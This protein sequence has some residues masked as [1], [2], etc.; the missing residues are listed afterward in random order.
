MGQ[1]GREQRRDVEPGPLAQDRG[2]LNDVVFI[3]IQEPALH[4]QEVQHFVELV[5][6]QFGKRVFCVVKLGLNFGQI[7]P[8]QAGGFQMTQNVEE[9]PGVDLF[10]QIKRLLVPV[11]QD[12]LEV[13]VRD[14]TVQRFLIV[15]DQM[16]GLACGFFAVGDCVGKRHADVLKHLQKI[17]GGDNPECGPVVLR[18]A[19]VVGEHAVVDHPF[20]LAEAREVV[21]ERAGGVVGALQNV[22]V[23]EIF[24]H[25]AHER[26]IEHVAVVGV[27]QVVDD[28]VDGDGAVSD[29]VVEVVWVF[30]GGRRDHG[31]LSHMLRVVKRIEVCVADVGQHSLETDVRLFVEPRLE[32]VTWH[33]VCDQRLQLD[34]LPVVRVVGSGGGRGA[35]VT[36]EVH[37]REV[38]RVRGRGQVA[39][40]RQ[41][42]ELRCPVA[43]K[44]DP[45]RDDQRHGGHGVARS[46]PVVVGALRAPTVLVREFFHALY[47]RFKRLYERAQEIIGSLKTPT[48]I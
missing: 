42:G 11:L 21:G 7:V 15:K 9:M 17:E 6:Q 44:P 43:G 34:A 18:P 5:L 38:E 37:D 28:G 12:V 33:G 45:Q 23:V 10:P 27:A 29:P 46:A 24:E 2:S 41:F 4:E 22:R 30:L 25:G 14:A 35:G 26:G 8:T 47:L 3:G 32:R 20:G 36:V 1:S 16:Q 13:Q 31:A 39:R 19:P 48:V 40:A